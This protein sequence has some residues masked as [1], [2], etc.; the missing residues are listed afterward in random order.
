MS[1]NLTEGIDTRT[2]MHRPAA[3][4]ILIAGPS[5]AG[6]DTLI[7]LAVERLDAGARLHIARRTVTRP[8]NPF[9][10]HASLDLEE[11]ERLERDGYFALSWCAH[12]LAYGIARTELERPDALV[13][14]SV[15]RTA[16]EYGRA[17]IPDASVILITAP[18]EVLAQRIAARGRETSSESRLARINLDEEL[19]VRPDL[20]IVNTGPPEQG[21]TMLA[22]FVRPRLPT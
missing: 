10:N 2:R 5:G 13:V 22:D 12:G 3:G 19:A 1:S 21:A 8:P 4:L 14:A 11:F 16:I 15:S 17:L 20:K 6:K 9:E 18:P 7:R